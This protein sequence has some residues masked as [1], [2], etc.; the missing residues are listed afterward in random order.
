MEGLF[1][2]IAEGDRLDVL[3]LIPSVV[4]AFDEAIIGRFIDKGSGQE[5]FRDLVKPMRSIGLSC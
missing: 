4:G 2:G 3:P 1:V 5:L